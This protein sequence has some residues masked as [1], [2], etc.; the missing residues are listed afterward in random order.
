[1]GSLIPYRRAILHHGIT[2]PS[3]ITRH[4]E[5]APRTRFSAFLCAMPGP[6]LDK[7]A[8]HLE[9]DPKVER[10]FPWF[11]RNLR[12]SKHF[13]NLAETLVSFVTLA[14]IQLAVRRLARA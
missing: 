14:S 7:P 1:M 12:L 6:L 9:P 13:E 11:R 5:S 4:A 2:R 8:Y 10:T 3:I